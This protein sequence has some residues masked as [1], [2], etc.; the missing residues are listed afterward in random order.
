MGGR[1]KQVER[2]EN[3][4]GRGREQRRGEEMKHRISRMFYLPQ[5]LVYY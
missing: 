2:R 5:Q 1:G 4:K 3:A